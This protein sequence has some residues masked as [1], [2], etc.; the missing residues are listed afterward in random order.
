MVKDIHIREMMMKD[1]ERVL[2]LLMRTPGIILRTA[3]SAD[4]TRGYLERNPGLSFI[5]EVG[6]QLVGCAMAGHDGRRGYLQHVIVAPEVRGQGIGKQLVSRCVTALNALG[7]HK[8]HLDVLE[9]NASA[10]S[11]WKHLG[12]KEREDIVR[13]SL[14][15]S[16]DENA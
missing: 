10:M 11:F 15:T 5:A 1:Y 2:E 4:A 16:E 13:F 9:E 12:W 7:I 3:D 8:M 14:I 6:S